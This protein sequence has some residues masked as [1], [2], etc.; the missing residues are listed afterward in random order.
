VRSLQMEFTDEVP[1]P[2]AN[3][4]E[5]RRLH[6]E[7]VKARDELEA[8]RKEAE[9]AVDG[10]E[11]A[12]SAYK[13]ARLEKAPKAKEAK[14]EAALADAKARADEPW[15]ERIEVAQID[16]D[17]ARDAAHRFA[18]AHAEEL[19][20]DD[21]VPLSLDAAT[22]RREAAEA[23]L[24]A[25]EFERQVERRINAAIV[26]MPGVFPRDVMP[27]EPVSADMERALVAVSN[28]PARVPRER[29]AA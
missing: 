12:S 13:V 17:D 25:M 11:L 21:L 7:A 10:V 8:I 29:T 15:R 6:A 26:F 1:E 3:A 2:S 27:R 9:E 19:I 22:R 14:A 16:F 28:L 20:A 23:L 5:W 24:D 4:Q 18:A